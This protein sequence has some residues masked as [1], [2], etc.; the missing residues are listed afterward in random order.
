MK[1][2]YQK[3][4]YETSKLNVNDKNKNCLKYEKTTNPYLIQFESSK[5]FKEL[6]TV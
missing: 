2:L 1:D 5:R 6:Y 4:V 3:I